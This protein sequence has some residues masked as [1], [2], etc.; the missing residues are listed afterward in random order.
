MTR[1]R[2]FAWRPDD[3]LVNGSEGKA[4]ERPDAADD[5]DADD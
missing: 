3:L 5:A 4:P 2:H 1:D